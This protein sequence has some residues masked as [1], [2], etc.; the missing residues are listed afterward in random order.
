[1]IKHES[2]F[3]VLDNGDVKSTAIYPEKDV[4]VI[5]GGEE[6]CIGY[7][8]PQH[9]VQIIHRGKIRKLYR[10]LQEQYDV[11][12]DRYREAKKVIEETK[13]YNNDVLAAEITRIN[14]EKVEQNKHLRNLNTVAKSVMMHH[15]AKKRLPELEH[16]LEELKKQLDF[17]DKYDKSV[18]KKQKI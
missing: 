1:M 11:L 16:T 2:K 5:I 3:E 17:L 13:D 8:E 15:E 14:M 10:Y 7:S 12:M 6:V 18:A 9:V 4:T